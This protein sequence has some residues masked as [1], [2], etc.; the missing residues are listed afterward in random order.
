MGLAERLVGLGTVRLPGAAAA[1]RL[2]AGLGTVRLPGA[3]AAARLLA[4]L[5]T[6][7][8]PGGGLPGGAAA[9]RLLAGIGTVRL[10]GGD[11]A[12]NINEPTGLGT[13]DPLGL[14]TLASS[15]K[16]VSLFRLVFS[17]VCRRPVTGEPRMLPTGRRTEPGG[18][19]GDSG[20]APPD[21]RQV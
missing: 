4:G 12:P 9:A 6:V 21:C 2:L 18:E 1:P 5:G 3:A 16:E 10:P 7:R 17:R 13:Y 20:I 11:T 15:W 8:L 14:G 19:P